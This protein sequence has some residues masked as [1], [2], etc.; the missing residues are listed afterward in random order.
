MILPP[1]A[2]FPPS[3][4]RRTVDPKQWTEALDLWTL[5]VNVW[6]STPEGSFNKAHDDH[7]H[8]QEFLCTFYNEI[9]LAERGDQ[10][11]ESPEA[12]RLRRGTF[13]LVHKFL[14][15]LSKHAL[16]DPLHEV[17]FL[18][19]FSY[20]HMKS[21]ALARLLEYAWQAHTVVIQASLREARSSLTS[22]LESSKPN[23][24]ELAL[25]RLAPLLKALPQAAAFMTEGSELMDAMFKAYDMGSDSLRAAI[26]P[27]AY[28]SLVSLTSEQTRNR[29]AL[30]D[31]LYSLKGQAE[32]GNQTT[33]LLADLVT[34][35]P[36]LFKLEGAV[37][38]KGVER[39]RTLAAALQSFRNPTIA[40]NRP[41]KRHVDKGKSAA[42]TD[43]NGDHH[44]H[45][46]SKITQ[47]Q[48][49]FPDL[50]SGFVA[51]LLDEYHEDVEVVTSHLLEDSL[52]PHLADLDRTVQIG[53]SRSQDPLS[54]SAIDTLI[55]ASTPSPTFVRRNVHD[56]DAF[57]RLEVDPSAYH[58]GRTQTSRTADDVLADRSAAP[59]KASILS[60]L[61]AF[62]SDDD[63]RDDTYDEADVGG[64][65]DKAGPDGEP[66][67]EVD[68]GG[69][70]NEETLWRAWRDDTR[71]FGRGAEVRRGAARDKLRRETGMTDEAI[72]G[73]GIMLGR[74]DRRQRR[75][76]EKY[77]FDG[78]QGSIG[79]TAFRQGEEIESDAER[80]GFR[81][82][83]RGRGRGG[84][85]R[86]RGRGGNVAGEPSDAQTQAAR[87]GK[88]ASKG[89]RA[90]HNRRDQRA[91]KMARGGF[92]G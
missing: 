74:D 89:S 47:I 53:V 5:T 91:K 25:R 23:D 82:R 33:N 81:G 20:A 67:A 16:D 38:E 65:V 54:Q 30:L 60:A 9:F 79:R 40:R 37:G 11:V 35:T 12:H 44:L 34:N 4:V 70:A 21:P 72:E 77:A 27:V 28:L 56:N 66:A 46:M 32:S 80:G 22:S 10:A 50:G 2:V 7:K 90:N 24:A 68:V 64:T 75:L 61:A 73:W 8:S 19:A 17:H 52:P 14:S 85:P 18:G 55:P 49:L 83:G 43:T 15:K 51:R 59:Q 62:D 48:D 69:D 45:L 41:R 84:A 78:R 88:E 71:L 39:A 57:D 58:R 92:A 3:E 86:G 76:E 63:E 31:H 26:V 87:R 13:L 1:F 42:T 6:L 29:S 36:L